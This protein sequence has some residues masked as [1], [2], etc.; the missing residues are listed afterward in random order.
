NNHK[1]LNKHYSQN[2]IQ[3]F[4]CYDVN[5]T[6]NIIQYAADGST[7]SAISA[8]FSNNSLIKN[9]VI[10]DINK[11]LNGYAIFSSSSDY[12]SIIRNNISNY[13]N[14]GIKIS[15]GGNANISY[16]KLISDKEVVSGIFLDSN[17]NPNNESIVSFNTIKIFDSDG[18]AL[19]NSAG[20]GS[21]QNSK[22]FNNVINVSEIGI[23][24]EGS[25]DTMAENFSV[26]NNVINSYDLETQ[27]ENGFKIKNSS[28]SFVYSN[29]INNCSNAILS[30]NTAHDFTFY[31]NLFNI[32][33]EV[34]D[35][36]SSSILSNIYFN[37]TNQLGQNIIGGSYIG[38]NFWSSYE[39]SDSSGDGIG[40]AEYTINASLGF[41]DYLPLVEEGVAPPAV[42][43]LSP[44]EGLVFNVSD[45]VEIS[46]NVT[47]SVLVD[48]VFAN[49]TSPLGQTQQLQL[50]NFGNYNYFTDVSVLNVSGRICDNGYSNSN[51]TLFL[52]NLGGGMEDVSTNNFQLNE[53]YING[54][55]SFGIACVDLSGM[56]GSDDSTVFYDYATLVWNDCSD[57]E[58]VIGAGNCYYAKPNVLIANG[59][60]EDYIFNG[61]VFNSTVNISSGYVSPPRIYPVGE[62]KYNQSF[63]VPNASGQYDIIF[64]VNDS[65]GNVNNTETTFFSV[66]DITPPVITGVITT[67]TFP[68]TNNG[69]EQNISVNFASNEYPLNI[70]FN[71]YNETWSVIDTQEPTQINSSSD[72]PQN[73]L[74]PG[75]L[76][77]G[78]Y[79]LNF[80]VTDSSENE[81]EISIGLFTVDSTF[82]IVTLINPANDS[83]DSDGN[84]TFSYNVSDSGTI[85]NCSFILNSILN[86]TN[87]SITKNTLQNFTINNLVAGNYNWSVDCTESS[88]N[89]GQS[90]KR[91]ISVVLVSK[92]AGDTTDLSSVNMSNITNLIIHNSENGR[93]NFS[94]SV[95]LSSGGDLNTY[96]NISNN[97]IEINS[98]AL[99]ALDKSARLYFYNLT[100]KDPRPLQ[101]GAVC[102][103]C[104]EVSY[105][106]GTFIYTVTGFSVYSSEETPSSS[107]SS[108]SSGGSSSG[109]RRRIVMPLQDIEM[110]MTLGNFRS[111]FNVKDK[112]KFIYNRVEYFII[113]EVVGKDYAKIN[114]LEKNRTFKLNEDQRIDLDSDG[115]N[116]LIIT[117]NEI[118]NKK[119]DF[120]FEIL[121]KVS[122][123]EYIRPLVAEKGEKEEELKEKGRITRIVGMVSEGLG[124]RIVFGGVLI[125]IILGLILWST[126]SLWIDIFKK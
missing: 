100:Y 98:T 27:C 36:D 22:I 76:I 6:S 102:S 109:G 64:V 73:Y 78:N 99:A 52:Y 11:S 14:E 110:D 56:G 105:S 39:G 18:I 59:A 57:V 95:D 93:I 65:S 10:E 23:R 2:G 29:V 43:V 54:T 68:L 55:R 15:S 101:D 104:T 49:I 80:T 114:I 31:N 85:E 86:Q 20:S 42:F 47:S 71:L 4:F 67:P 84:I 66:D 116:D 53:A 79:T 16:N 126:K 63:I 1:K 48:T 44:L 70:T 38:G 51:A 33:G 41:Y 97:R 32:T 118:E 103:S 106:G 90:E 37:V 123:K 119:A 40:D 34:F 25:A 74:I 83:G 50:S 62:E 121:E 89:V 28:S 8:Y 21:A 12:T 115:K 94:E 96:I 113:F 61:S 17:N 120:S 112:V 60:G 13:E 75:N 125:V 45:S 19:Y 69:T 46:V 72:L 88:L 35:F 117:L 77:S 7:V 107:S 111:F 30:E 9:N 82:P 92:F 108:S 26:Y 122:E 91:I 24:L 124:G 81:N 87:S 58:G 3:C 5:V